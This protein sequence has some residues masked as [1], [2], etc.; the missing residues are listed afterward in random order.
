M[1]INRQTTLLN[2]ISD[3]VLTLNKYGRITSQTPARKVFFDTNASLIGRDIDVILQL[4]DYGNKPRPLREIIAETK[5]SSSRDD[6][7]IGS[8]GE[9]TPL[10][11]TDITHT[12]H[13]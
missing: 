1:Q 6:L 11:H 9:S 2:G 5:S 3:A 13:V 7:S 10:K 12:R 4:R 8:G